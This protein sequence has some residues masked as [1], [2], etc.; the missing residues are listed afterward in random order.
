MPRSRTLLSLGAAV[1]LSV[2]G[3]SMS[4]Q[5]A[6]STKADQVEI[7]PVVVTARKMSG[8]ELRRDNRRLRRE[9]AAYDRKIA[10]LEKHLFWLKTVVTDS[11]RRD[12]SNLH[13]AADSTHALRLLL[14][15]RVQE[16]ETRVS[17][18]H[19]SELR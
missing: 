6:G 8:N 18:G 4:A 2:A 5:E 1:A 13:S 10:Y 19:L 16:A 7:A 14:E 15:E 11:L 12:I 9:L 17:Q 3:T